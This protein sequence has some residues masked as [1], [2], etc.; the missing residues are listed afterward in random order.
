[1]SIA[2]VGFGT[3]GKKRFNI[4]KNSKKKIYIVD[5][6]YKSAHA[7]K[8]ENLKIKLR[9][10]FVCTPDQ[11]KLKIINFLIKNKVNV[12]VE[13][14]FFLKSIKEYKTIK[15]LLKKYETKLYI[16]YNHRFEPNLIRL[17]KYLDKKI[18]GKIYSVEMYY[19]NGT[20][21]LWSNSIWRQKDN[22]GVVID[23]AP[24]LLDTYIYLFG[25]LP[26][27]GDFFLNNNFENTNMDFAKFGFKKNDICIT[28]TTSL[29]D[30]KN[31]FEINIIGNKGSLHV[32]NLCK[33]DDSYLIYRKR[34]LPSG[35]PNEK[36]F[37]EKMGDP[38]WKLEHNYFFR[39]LKKRRTNLNND[40]II[41]KFIDELFA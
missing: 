33:W 13:K 17:K 26:A 40:I 25:N 19:G 34:I 10:A 15:R 16:A 1:M 31:N 41:K 23:L 36:V 29:I 8:I 35:K 11:E 21:K 27:K 14:P 6:L 3:Q 30:W 38:T 20:S 24:H 28:L 32:K 2:I 4:L 5:P 39:K 18:I 9:Y 7:K 12:L 37:I 22:K